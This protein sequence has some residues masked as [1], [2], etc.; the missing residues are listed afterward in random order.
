[1][2]ISNHALASLLNLHRSQIAEAWMDLILHIPDS[3]YRSIQRADIRASC[4]R[5]IDALLE[6]QE[7]NSEAGIEQYIRLISMKRLEQGFEIQEI[8][9]ALLLLHK[10]ILMVNSPNHIR[11]PA[12]ALQIYEDLEVSLRVLVSKFGSLYASAMNKSLDAQQ[13]QA[14][15]LAY[16]NAI[17]YQETQQRL[18]ES[19]SLQRVTSALLQGRTLHEVLAVVCTEAKNLIKARGSTVFLLEEDCLL[20]VAYSLGDGEPSF[21]A[22]PV[23]ASFTGTVI[24]TGKAVFTNQPNQEELWYGSTLVDQQSGAIRSL[25][26]APL[27]IRARIIGALV[28]VNKEK[29]FDQDDLRVMGLFADQA[30]IAIE[31]GRLIQE[32]EQI[33]VMEERNRLA[34]DLH[35]SVTQSLYGVSLY[36]EAAARRLDSED[37]PG[38]AEYL[39]EL[40]KT[41]LDALK[42]MRLLIF[43]L[44]PPLLDKEG[45]EAALQAR[46]DAV[47]GRA[48]LKTEL[49]VNMDDRLPAKI[50]DG[51]YRIAQEA[52]NNVLKHAQAHHVMVMLE[53]H[54]GMAVLQISDDGMGFNVERAEE[55]GGVGIK[56]MRERVQSI[57]GAL[58]ITSR[59]DKGTCIKVQVE[60]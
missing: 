5:G 48:G 8:I 25:L 53:A 51:L 47:E 10:A 24:T 6:Y 41:A 38:V 2:E 55:S 33:A 23:E 58:E 20:H 54:Q 49:R 50:E 21:Q 11:N 45:L 46:L 37:Y 52:L 15:S 27:M 40:R 30:A 36:A 57:G 18:V 42:E 39:R 22:M 1:M 43:E 26:A 3:H 14:Q 16:E 56:G 12:Q 60:L 34:R 44:R 32:V 4:F 9:Q 17:L 28:V 31:N 35:D 29:L 13:Q 7:Q 19:V 59:P